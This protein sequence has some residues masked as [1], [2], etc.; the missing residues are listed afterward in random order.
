MDAEVRGFQK[1]KRRGADLWRIYFPLC[2]LKLM[3]FL[4]PVDQEHDERVT[5]L[6]EMA[7][8]GFSW[9]GDY[10]RFS[11]SDEEARKRDL[12]DSELRKIMQQA[13]AQ[14]AEAAPEAKIDNAGQAWL[15]HA[16]AKTVKA[17]APKAE[18][19]ADAE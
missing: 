4:V 10:T 18:A 2:E 11:T 17:A 13:S 9:I 19:P 8:T 12:T 7:W 1:I 14:A 15:S 5:K 16:A 3:K 6:A